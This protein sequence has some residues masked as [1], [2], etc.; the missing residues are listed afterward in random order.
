MGVLVKK[1]GGQS[2]RFADSDDARF[3]YRTTDAGV[4]RVIQISGDKQAI[5]Q[6]YSPTGWMGVTGERYPTVVGDNL[7]SIEGDPKEEVSNKMYSF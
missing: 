7:G 6:E 5:A 1:A 3:Y 2:K 4:L